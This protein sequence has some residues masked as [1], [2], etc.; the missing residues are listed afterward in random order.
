M[1]LDKYLAHGGYGTRNE[2]KKLIKGGLVSINDQLVKKEGTHVNEDD[3]V[4]VGLEEVSYDQQIYIMFNK[5]EGYVC[6]SHDSLYPTVIEALDQ[7][8]HYDLFCIGRLDLDTTGLI[9][10][11]NDGQL[12]HRIINGKKRIDKVYHALIDAH[13]KQS[14]IEA[15]KEGLTLEDG[16]HTKQASLKELAII[17]ENHSVVEVKISEG[18][19]HQ[20]KRMLMVLG[21]HVSSLK[22]VAIGGLEL[23]ETLALGAYKLLNEDDLRKVF[24]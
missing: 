16:Y 18:K 3:I 23:D 5:D 14:D 10:V 13:I 24:K 17:D 2:V 9:L 20:V 12:A 7:Y 6:A 1:R 19:Y 21:Y 22:R 4:C 8:E 11:T 15:F